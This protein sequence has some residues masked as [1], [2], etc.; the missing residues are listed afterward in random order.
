MMRSLGMWIA[1]ACLAA[2][3]A[4][5][6]QEQ[7]KSSIDVDHY[8]IDAV[9]DVDRQALLANATVTFIPL[10]AGSNSAT[11]EL[12]NALSVSKAVDEQGRNLEVNRSA[13]DFT[14][15]VFFPEPLA[16]S[17]PVSVKFTYEGRLT[18]QEESPISGIQFGVIGKDAIWLLYP[19]RWFPISGYT[20]DRYTMDLTVTVPSGYRV[21]SS[22]IDSAQ[23]DAYSFKT[24]KP[25]F[26]GSLAITKDTVKKVSSQ[27]LTNDVWFRA[28][29]QSTAQA[30]GEETAKAMVFLTSLFGV[31]PQA[32]L[33]IVETGEGAPNGYSAAGLLF[34]SPSTAAKP[35][36]SR[37]LANQ[38]A[39][40]WFGGLL[41]PATRN[42]IWVCNG[43]AKYAEVLYLESLNG[44][45]SVEPEIHELYV[46]SL[47]V[48][49]A[50]VRQSNRYED[51]SPEFFAVTGSK[52]AA[53]L[54]MLRW[55]VGD[56]NFKTI[57][58]TFVDQ[59]A[60]KSVTTDDFRKV[61]E[62]VAGQ[63]LQGFFIQWLESTGAPEFKKEYTVFRIAKGFRTVGKIT[64]DLD[65]F[66]MPVEIKIETEGNPEFKRIDVSG[67]STEFSVE[68]FGKP[69]RLVLD[70]NGRLL[71]NSSK[72]RV[73]VAIRRGEQLAEIGEYTEALQEYQ[74]ALGVNRISS[75][76]HY[77]VGEVFFLQNNYQSAANEFREAL[78]GDGEPKWSEV[79][80]HINLGKIFDMTQQRERAR[81][82]YQQ[83]IRTK[84]NTQGAQEQAAKY[85]QTPYQRKETN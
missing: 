43:V 66:R 46:D 40:Q 81:N 59:F 29:E 85:L 67:P 17:K 70:P 41:S 74:K 49:D 56:P 42:H 37:L 3:A 65:T 10:D 5:F 44:P 73:D 51:Y 2:P 24:S 14:V 19:A 23:G 36:S 38:I 6:A 9:I 8:K 54:N 12:N 78:N 57:L 48:T 60:G 75:L 34:I 83:A 15:K 68:T 1:L 26:P 77:R 32:N 63:P 39:R 22:G 45:Q 47:T 25:A 55:I 79:W 31:P 61:A 50:P 80:S 16:K 69:K 33:T 4:L 84:D 71:T 52:G 64:Q 13:Q 28:S 21:L 82:E 35:P 27:G 58:H 7:R 11:F 53:T 62:T 72:M 76:A 30:W 18:G 20:T